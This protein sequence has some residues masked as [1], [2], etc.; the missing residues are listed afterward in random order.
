MAGVPVGLNIIKF[1]SGLV[2]AP[3]LSPSPY[4]V[5]GITF[6]ISG[7]IGDSSWNGNQHQGN[8]VFHPGFNGTLIGSLGVNN[9]IKIQLGAN[10]GQTMSIYIP[11]VD[12][13]SLNIDTLDIST[14]SGAVAS[15]TGIDNAIKFISSARSKCGAYQ[16]ALEHVNNNLLNYKENIKSAQSRIADADIAKEMVE[17]TKIRILAQAGQTVLAQANQES[18]KVIQLLQ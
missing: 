7:A 9:S 18:K 3:N 4:S 8:V 15:I 13:Q 11:K 17:L 16:N 6:D 14:R 12:A 10:S 2:V 1:P 5:N